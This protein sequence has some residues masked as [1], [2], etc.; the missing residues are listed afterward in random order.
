MAMIAYQIS[1]MQ[2]LSII[3]WY[4]FAYMIITIALLGFGVAG[5]LL[6]IFRNSL[7]RRKEILIPLFVFLSGLS[8]PLC[9]WLSSLGIA[10]FDTYLL[11]VEM[12]HVGKLLVFELLFITPFLFSALAIG[13]LFTVHT[14]NIGVLYFSNLVGSGLGGLVIIILF[15][16]ATP[17]QI[18]FFI[19]LI[20]IIAAGLMLPVKQRSWSR[21]GVIIG[22]LILLYFGINSPF[23]LNISQYK[24]LSKAKDLPQT[25]IETSINSPFGYVQYISSPFLRAAP[26]VSL[27]YTGDIPVS[28]AIF[29][30]AEWAGIVPKTIEETKILDFTPAAIIHSLITPEKVLIL[31]GGTGVRSR[32]Y[33][34]KGSEIIDHVEP[35]RVISDL[36][37]LNRID[38]IDVYNE[39]ART[40]LSR[41]DS[42]YDLIVLPDLGDFGGD[43]G[44]KSIN[45]NYL[46]TQNSFSRILD[47]LGNY[48][49]LNISVWTDHPLRKPLRITATLTEALIDNGYRKPENHLIAIRSWN[50][51]TYLLRK[52]PFSDSEITK[53][54]EFCELLS[55]DPL[56]L[57]GI[58]DEERNNY[59]IIEDESLFDLTDE[60]LIGDREE[61]YKSYDFNIKPV[62]DDQ[63]YFFQFLKLKSFKK[64]Q[65]LFG[66]QNAL[67]FELGYLMV[68]ITFLQSLL[69]AVLFIILPLIFVKTKLKNKTWT[70]CYFSGIGLGFMLIEILFIQYFILFLGQPAYSVAMVIGIML[71]SAGMGSWVSSKYP[72]SISSLK[73][74]GTIIV[75][76]LVLYAFFL[77]GTLES[78]ISW[79]LPVKLIFS[80]S[81]IGL[82][83]FFMGFPFPLGLRF[84]SGNNKKGVPWA[85]AINSFTSVISASM[86][87]LLAV[88]F[89]YKTIF[90]I[91]SLAYLLSTGSCY[92]IKNV[93][94]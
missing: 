24:A 36:S 70:F 83:S 50:N 19:G 11:F 20:A 57:P 85:W 4:H 66:N 69:L 81:I 52:K 82:P 21:L 61:V 31:D 43:V 8:M 16:M 87:I 48:G 39:N 37:G 17:I 18:P 6:T 2:I 90:F 91:A 28:D 40:F 92:L 3:Q 13:L 59:N 93:E 60:I 32:Y 1:L 71:L 29:N 77:P 22:L 38:E 75:L 25:E 73:I 44:L 65:N 86:A 33:M 54:R 62:T 76:L 12:N 79:A 74:S 58:Q 34:F 5:T 63:P 27:T 47:R 78:G 7:A 55:F 51:I 88:A 10:D 23:Q 64:L 14:K 80:I 72:S 30:N 53:V 41:V 94:K 49:I 89:G 68:G 15:W 42:K 9:L 84:V 45:E 56:I 67:F 46:F 35:N 26:A